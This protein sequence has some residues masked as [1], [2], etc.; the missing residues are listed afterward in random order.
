MY[1]D[2]YQ[3]VM[4][5]IEGLSEGTL[6]TR[7]L[8]PWMNKNALAAYFTSCTSSHYRWARKEMRKGFRALL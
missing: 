5:T 1:R 4:A 3:E 2:S 8:Y 7:G 6:F